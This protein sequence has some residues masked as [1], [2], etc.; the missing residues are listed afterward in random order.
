[1]VGNVTVFVDRAIDYFSRGSSSSGKSDNPSQWSLTIFLFLVAVGFCLMPLG[2][3]GIIGHDPHVAFWV[4]PMVGHVLL[5]SP[6]AIIVLV[7]TIYILQLSKLSAR[8]TK[9]VCTAVVLVAG[10]TWVLAGLYLQHSFWSASAELTTS[11]G[12]TVM[13]MTMQGTWSKLL[14]FQTAC[15]REQDDENV[16]V[17]QCPG[18]IIAFGTDIVAQYL[19]DVEVDFECQGFCQFYSRPFFIEEGTGRRCAVMIAEDLDQNGMV[20]CV[21]LL[22]SGGILLMV[23]ACLA[24]YDHL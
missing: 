6:I 3:F 24:N 7:L 8:V 4:G 5:F 12:S 16:L 18:F 23:A 21:P 10:V 15:G 17:Q 9:T 20:C 19:Q 14:N 11:C 1:M 22:S 13:T 2:A